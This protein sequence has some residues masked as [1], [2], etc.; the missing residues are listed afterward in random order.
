MADRQGV[1]IGDIPMDSLQKGKRLEGELNS[2]SFTRRQK[3]IP[4]ASNSLLDA[5]KCGDQ[6][7]Q[8]P[9]FNFLKR[10]DIELGS[11]GKLFLG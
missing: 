5:D 10:A 9:S 2:I 8:F 3:L 6:D 4:T 11:F 1:Q 7:I